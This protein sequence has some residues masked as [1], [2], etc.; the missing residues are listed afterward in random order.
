MIQNPFFKEKVVSGEVHMRK[1]DRQIFLYALER[2][3]REPWECIFVDNSV[4]NLR[5]A[6][7]FGIQTILFN[8][9]REDYE[10]R[11]VND[12]AELGKMLENM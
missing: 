4:N 8:R 9:D 12:F 2:L 11:V 5:A 1:P 6:K 3:K 7:E 10:G